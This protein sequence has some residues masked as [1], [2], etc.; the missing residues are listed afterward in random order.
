MPRFQITGWYDEDI[1]SYD[2]SASESRLLLDEVPEAELYPGQNIRNKEPYQGRHYVA[3]VFGRQADGSSIAVRLMGFAPYLYIRVGDGETTVKKHDAVNILNSIRERVFRR[4]VK[5]ARVVK[6]IE[7]YGFTNNESRNY[8]HVAFLTKKTMRACGF[9]LWDM[10]IQCQGKSQKLHPYESHIDPL[11]R[12]IHIQ[13]LNASG[14]VDIDDNQC[15]LGTWSNTTLCFSTS[16][17]NIKPAPETTGLAPIVALSFDIECASRNRIDFPK[18]VQNYAKVAG[19]IHDIHDRAVDKRWSRQE[20]RELIISLILRALGITSHDSQDEILQKAIENKITSG[21]DVSRAFPKRTPDTQGLITRLNDLS[22]DIDDFLR[23]T[24]TYTEDFGR[25]DKTQQ[26]TTLM[27]NH[28]PQLLGDEII[29]IGAT[30]NVVGNE[31]CNY[32]WIG[33]LGQCSPIPGVNVESFDKEKDLL[34]A[35]SR[36]IIE[37]D[38]DIYNGYN[39]WGFDQ[40]YLFERSKELGVQTAFMRMSKI[41]HTPAVYEEKM[42]SSSA[43]GANHNYLITIPGRVNIDLIHVMRKDL[44]LN[45]YSLNSVSRHILK[46][47]KDDVSAQDIFRLQDGTDEDRAVIAKYCVQDCALVTRLT[48]KRNVVVNAIAMANVCSIPLQFI[49]NRGQG[50]K[51][52]SQVARECRTRGYVMKTHPREEDGTKIMYD[53]ARVLPPKTGIYDKP[54]FCLDYASLYPSCMMSHNICATSKVT[55]ERYLNLPNF[56]YNE[57]SFDVYS[58]G[59]KVDTKTVYYAQPLSGEKAV[60]PSIEETLK[61]KRSETRAKMKWKRVKLNDGSSFGGTTKELSNGNYVVD[62]REIPAEQIVDIESYYTDFEKNVLNGEQLAYKVTG[63]SLYGA[64]GASTSDIRD[65]DCAASITAVGRELIDLAKKFLED[66]GCTVVYGDT[67]SCFAT[68]P[69]FDEDGNEVTGPE[70]IPLV[71]ERAKELEK[72]FISLLPCPHVCEY[73]KVYYPWILLS[74]KRYLGYLYEEATDTPK[75]SCNGIVLVRRDN[76]DAL[77]DVV[78]DVC[79]SLL[80]LDVEKALQ[81]LYTSVDNLIEGRIPLEKLTITKTLGD[82]YKNPH[83]IPHWVLAQRIGRR[84]PAKKPAS[85]SRVAYAFI[86][87]QN[88]NCLQ[89]DR[90]ETPEYIQEKNLKIDYAYYLEHQIITPVCQIM[91]TVLEKLP[92][93]KTPEHHWNDL[94]KIHLA[95][96]KKKF[97]DNPEEAEF[98]TRKK[99]DEARA[100]NVK[101]LIFNPILVKLTNRNNKQLPITHFFRNH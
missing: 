53:G 32:K 50:I 12:L 6:G 8:V 56:K 41:R 66:N 35:F 52:T 16:F 98:Q 26:V 11:L 33:T 34:L 83:T 13:E 63:N 10:N 17:K 15:V 25:S 101:E 28:L 87:T 70:A 29:Q 40:K 94:W 86:V 95:T 91:S 47:E 49:F 88:K 64:Q 69:V 68:T 22:E 71:I 23:N 75:F 20:T 74:K 80:A 46:D 61:R 85:N 2:L 24:Y 31:E 36:L 19:D 38:P 37:K 65:V 93:Y 7:Y 96:F 77:K 14:W 30:F 79:K 60:L 62:G 54:V 73:E 100:Q 57:V 89:G 44:K 55:N 82:S 58:D 1:E 84:D 5:K 59:K 76:C 90:I 45:S 78:T 67:D 42:L 99:V 48:E 92:G 81:G 51:C 3:T 43:M 21:N 9:N 72:K 18:A 97:P 4:E 39:V 27:N